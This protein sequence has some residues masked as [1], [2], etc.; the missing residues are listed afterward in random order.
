MDNE[1]RCRD[2]SAVGRFCDSV[3][4]VLPCFFQRVG[5]AMGRNSDVPNFVP[6]T[7]PYCAL[8]LVHAPF[9]FSPQLSDS[10]Q[11]VSRQDRQ[12]QLVALSP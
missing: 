3:R 8:P 9:R 6:T 4:F 5:I 12:R 2:G 7:K 10:V 11:S 1:I